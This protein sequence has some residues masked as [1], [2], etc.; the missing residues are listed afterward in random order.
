MWTLQ[1]D[2]LS[3]NEKRNKKGYPLVAQIELMKLLKLISIKKNI[4]DNIWDFI[5]TTTDKDKIKIWTTQTRL[6]TN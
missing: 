3:D 2:H 5:T 1:I 4:F 6:K